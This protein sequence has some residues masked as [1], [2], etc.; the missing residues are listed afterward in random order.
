MNE[1]ISD[2]ATTARPMN[3]EAEEQLTMRL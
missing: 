1:T 2:P 3:S